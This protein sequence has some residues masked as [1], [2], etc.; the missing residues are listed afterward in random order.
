MKAMQLEHEI[1][2]KRRQDRLKQTAEVFTPNFLI[3]KMLD[4][5]PQEVWKKGKTFCDPA[6][7]NGNFLIWVLIRKNE[8]NHTPLEALRCLY[9]VDIMQDN[10]RECRLR[11]LRVVSLFEPITEDHIKVVFQNIVFLNSKRYRTGV[12]EY[13]FSFKNKINNNT[14][15]RWMDL[16]K[17]GALNEVTLP[18]DEEIFGKKI[19]VF[20]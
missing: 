5:L 15:Q 4:K 8:R 18:V 17:H 6:C 9:G 19:H 2:E 13:N 12:L 16:I 10:I 1:H 7:G 20:T 14:V 11:L 3:N